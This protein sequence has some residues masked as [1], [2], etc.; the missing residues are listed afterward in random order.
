LPVLALIGLVVFRSQRQRLAADQGY[1]RARGAS[2]MARKRLAAARSKATAAQAEAFYA[3]LALAAIAYI[4]DK[5][6][7]SPHG[8]TR[9][10]IAEL[11]KESRAHDDLTGEIL[12]FLQRCDFAR[13]AAASVTQ[14]DI[15]RDLAA[16]EQVMVKMEGVTFGR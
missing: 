14:E 4:A 15:T 11:L 8:L 13:F 5:L 9:D 1:A 16:A 2:R 10:R 6:D 12:T 3:E 7:I